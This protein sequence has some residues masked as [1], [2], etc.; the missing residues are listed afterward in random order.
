MNCRMDKEIYLQSPCRSASIP[1]WKAN[2]I[3]VPDDMQI[4]HDADFDDKLLKEYD[5]VPYFRLMHTLERLEKPILLEN[6]T[7]R[8]AADAVLAAHINAC[9]G[10]EC[11]DLQEIKNW[12]QRKVYS[13]DLWLTVYDERTGRI[14]ASGIAEIDREIG[15]GVLEWIQV[16][17]SYRKRGLGRFIV[18]KLLWRM[19]KHARFATVSGKCRDA[20]NPEKLYRSCGFVGNDVWHVLRKRRT[21]DSIGRNQ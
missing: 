3:A 10:A 6:F 16:E 8:K 5:D 9:Y 14:A 13:E 17:P 11:V 7:L 18:Q 20:S 19:Q 1:Y 2:L 12:R 15:E 4:V 21:Y